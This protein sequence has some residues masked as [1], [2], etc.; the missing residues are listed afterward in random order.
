MG[1]AE[2][3]GTG[4]IDLDISGYI[5]AAPRYPGFMI[6]PSLEDCKKKMRWAYEHQEECR[7]IGEKGSKEVHKKFNWSKIIKDLEQ[8][9]IL[10]TKNNVL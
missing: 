5:N 1:M 8:Y 7:E 10:A 3:W 2:Q 6:M 4:Y 9:L